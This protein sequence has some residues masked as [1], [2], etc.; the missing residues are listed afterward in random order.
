MN[1][2]AF[3]AFKT[4]AAKGLPVALSEACRAALRAAC[5]EIVT[6]PMPFS[7]DKSGAREECSSERP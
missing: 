4:R 6:H 5:K 2:A 1:E 3:F 7:F